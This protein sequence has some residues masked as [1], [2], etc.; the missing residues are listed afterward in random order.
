MPKI[1][2]DLTT[3]SGWSSLSDGIHSITVKAKA[4]GYRDSEPSEA[5]TVIKGHI[6]ETPTITL[7]GSLLSTPIVEGVTMYKVYSN[8][9]YIGYVD[10]NNVWHEEVSE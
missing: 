3:L 9:N 7:T 1:N 5:V 4:T 2:I 8:G 10:S 6:W